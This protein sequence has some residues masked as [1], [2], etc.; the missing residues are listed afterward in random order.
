MATTAGKSRSLTKRPR[1]AAGAPIRFL[2]A[3]PENP[4]YSL[5]DPALWD[6]LLEGTESSSGERINR[7]AALAYAAYWRGVHLISRDVAKLP[8][9]L[10]RRLSDG[11]RERVRDHPA[12]RLLR[13]KS[14]PQV[15]AFDLKSTLQSHALIYG[16]GYGYIERSGD[17]LPAAIWPMDPESVYCVRADG[18]LWYVASFRMTTDGAQ[19]QRKLT[20]ESVL[21]VRGLGFDGLTGYSVLEY[22]RDTLG[23]GLGAR[24][25]GAIYFKNGAT[26]NVILEHPGYMTETA[27]ARLRESWNTMHAGLSNAHKTAV[28]QEGL[29]AN[30]LGTE[31]RR[32]QMVELRQFEIREIANVLNIPSHKLGDPSPRSYASVEAENQAYLDEGLDAWLVQWEE[33]CFDKLL[34]EEEKRGDEYYFEFNRAAL[35]RADIATRYAAYNTALQGGWMTRNE[36]RERENMNPLEGGD[37]P[38]QPLN[39]APISEGPA[40]AETEGKAG[41]RA[42]LDILARMA[43]R[44]ATQAIRASR[45]TGGLTGWWSGVEARNREVV[46]RALG[47]LLRGEEL[48]TLVDGFFADWYEFGQA[49]SD[50]ESIERF[51]AELPDLLLREVSDHA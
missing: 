14:C 12:R 34:T 38:L 41:R 17:G 18:V 5:S 45:R 43:R 36:I 22:A 10:Y 19:V 23:I 30:V 20:P 6:A 32:A 49:D 15:K 44:V 8:M 24:K 11:G 42:L 48:D 4:Q 2:R 13:R 39:M 47:V 3:S 21:H 1:K 46:T 9:D 7:K 26:A 28:L 50:R 35:V 29:K 16:N 25:F 37:V 33:E 51:A 31:P 40:E 27:E